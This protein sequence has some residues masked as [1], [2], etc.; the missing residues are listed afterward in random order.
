MRH[1][2]PV[3][4][5]TNALFIASRTASV[6]YRESMSAD[7]LAKALASGSIPQS[8]ISHMSTLIDEAPV[9]I[10]YRAVEEASSITKASRKKIWSHL[11][12]WAYDFKSPRIIWDLTRKRE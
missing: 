7:E 5:K 10:L 1:N 3:T 8:R 2:S 6:S 4:K 11:N 9:I 12:Q